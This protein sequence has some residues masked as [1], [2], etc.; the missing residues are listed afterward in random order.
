MFVCC[1]I[2]H[3]VLRHRERE[4]EKKKGLHWAKW[5][6][7]VGCYMISIIYACVCVCACAQTTFILVLISISIPNIAIYHKHLAWLQ[8]H[9]PAQQLCGRILAFLHCD[10]WF[11]IWHFLFPLSLFHVFMRTCLPTETNHSPDVCVCEYV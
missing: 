5:N 1:Y 9:Y 11:S 4:T 2:W 10:E 3:S 6:W 7:D 8:T